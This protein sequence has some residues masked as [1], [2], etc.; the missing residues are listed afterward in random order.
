MANVDVSYLRTADLSKA[1]TTCRK[2]ENKFKDQEIK[3]A[4]YANMRKKFETANEIM[5]T[6]IEESKQVKVNIGGEE[7][8]FYDEFIKGKEAVITIAEINTL[9]EAHRGEVTAETKSHFDKMGTNDAVVVNTRVD[10]I[11]TLSQVGH[12]ILHGKGVGKGILMASA[13]VLIGELLTQSI[14]SK[15]VADGV[16]KSSM[17]LLGL[18]EMGLNALPGLWQTI[19]GSLAAFTGIS[20]TVL[21]ASGVFAVAAAIPMVTHL[22]KKVKSKVK[23]A[24]AFEE[25]MKKMAEEGLSR[26]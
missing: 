18:G 1:I 2:Q 21:V 22:V 12:D 14:T 4:K 26:S 15:L 5:K 17:G 11:D 16:L 20:S 3:K 24:G 10:F 23:E 9:K 7:K 25:N 8:S 13:G 6:S 19:S